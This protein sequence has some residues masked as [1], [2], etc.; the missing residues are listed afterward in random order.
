MSGRFWICYRPGR[1][2]GWPQSFRTRKAAEEFIRE[3]DWSEMMHVLETE[4][5]AEK[6]GQP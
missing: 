5:P 3:N 6:K 4:G 2:L 1:Q